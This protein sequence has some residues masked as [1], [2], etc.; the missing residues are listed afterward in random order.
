MAQLFRVMICG[1]LSLR[2]CFPLAGDFCH[3]CVYPL[4]DHEERKNMP[5]SLCHVIGGG[6]ML[7]L[8]A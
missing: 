7:S 2:D 6:G 3:G 4:E 1:L 5:P 8:K